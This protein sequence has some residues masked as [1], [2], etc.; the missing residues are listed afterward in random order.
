MGLSFSQLLIYLLFTRRCPFCN[1]VIK[2]E[3]HLCKNCEKE[4]PLVK[5]NICKKCG[6]EKKYCKC[7]KMH[8]FDAA[9][10]PLYYEKPFNKGLLVFKNN[11]EKWRAKDFAAYMAATFKERFYDEEIDFAVCVPDHKARIHDKLKGPRIGYHVSPTITLASAVSDALGIELKTNILYFAKETKTRQQ[12]LSLHARKANVFG[13]IDVNFKDCNLLGKNV[14]IIDD[15][16]T[17]GATTSECA[18]MLKLYGA[19]KVFVVTLFTAKQEK[20]TKKSS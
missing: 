17:T 3:D 12:A 15:V 7:G 14:L 4:L 18:K 9:V 20:K 19:D 6:C 1:E 5:G 10:A 13:S 11:R 2:F 16:M 8:E